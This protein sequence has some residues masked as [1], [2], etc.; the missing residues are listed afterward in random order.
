MPAFDQ[1]LA[2]LPWL[3]PLADQVWISLPFLILTSLATQGLVCLSARRLSRLKKRSSYD[4][5]ARQILL[6]ASC[7]GLLLVV[8]VKGLSFWYSGRWFPE[9]MLS[10]VWEMVWIGLC[11]CVIVLN[12]HFLLWKK[13]AKHE[14]LD[15]LFASTSL[16]FGVMVA[17][18]ALVLMRLWALG[19]TVQTLADT[20]T[21]LG[22]LPTPEHAAFV[23]LL[24]FLPLFLV[25][26]YIF[27]SLAFLVLR[28]VHDFGRDHYT[29]VTLWTTRRAFWLGLLIV[30]VLGGCFGFR[31]YGQWQA[32]TL[33]LLDWVEEF[34]LL[35]LWLFASLIWGGISQS[36]VP[37]RY[38][39]LMVFA[40]ILAFASCPL[41]V[42]F[43]LRAA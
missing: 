13:L 42:D 29:M 28:N 17:V 36:T 21:L 30:F 14:I 35:G 6:V 34:V 31:L 33:V 37:L 12:L 23:S 5:G 1:L 43:W 20:N 38:K 40:A 26:P 24:V 10:F 22:L 15:H 18:A 32:G 7:V 25:M 9:D 8:A 2:W 16:L 39:V 3:S 27:A 19:G 41:L 11:F 4:K